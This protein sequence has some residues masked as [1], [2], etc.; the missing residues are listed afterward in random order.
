MKITHAQ[1][2]AFEP[3]GRRNSSGGRST[4]VSDATIPRQSADSP[5]ISC[6]AGS[7]TGSRARTRGASRSCKRRCL[8]HA[9]VRGRARL[10]DEAPHL[11]GWLTAD[12]GERDAAFEG[13]LRDTNRRRVAVGSSGV[14]G[15]DGTSAGM[16]EKQYFEFLARGDKP[17]AFIV[18]IILPARDVAKIP[19]VVNSIL[20]G[21]E[22]FKGRVGFVF[23]INSHPRVS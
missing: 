2:A 21:A 15:A 14:A 23:G 17:M 18:N 7:C 10:R 9:H 4:M 16:N 11:A 13:L 8:C 12:D 20:K 6:S 1:M 19:N 5:T 22:G 3:G